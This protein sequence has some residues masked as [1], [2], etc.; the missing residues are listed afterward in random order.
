VGHIGMTLIGA[1]GNS[2]RKLVAAALSSPQFP[3]GM[4]RLALHLKGLF[5]ETVPAG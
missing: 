4:S 1:I 3:H 5:V 2:L